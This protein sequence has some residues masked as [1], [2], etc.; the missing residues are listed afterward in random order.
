MLQHG[1]LDSRLQE[2]MRMTN[3]TAEASATNGINIMAHV[4]SAV[5]QSKGLLDIRLV[6]D[7]LREPL[8]KPTQLEAPLTS[9]SSSPHNMEAGLFICKDAIN[10]ISRVSDGPSESRFS[11]HFGQLVNR[12]N[13]D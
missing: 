1:A 5:T 2:I 4:A 10:F 7:L 9:T 6:A 12:L 3:A 11:L 8:L 13:H